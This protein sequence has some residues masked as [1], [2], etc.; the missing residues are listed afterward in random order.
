MELKLE[1]I[2]VY[3]V[4]SYPEAN[5]TNNICELCREPILGP[6]PENIKSGD[7]ICSIVVGKCK[8][9][10]HTECFNKTIKASCPIDKTPWL[11]ESKIVS[12]KESARVIKLPK[13]VISFQRAKKV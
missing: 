13:K 11:L 9:C 8:H 12:N 4:W 7:Y 3:S 2:N 5:V 10:F 1:S 6:S